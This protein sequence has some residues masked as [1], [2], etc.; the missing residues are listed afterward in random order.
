MTRIDKWM[1]KWGRASSSVLETVLE[2]ARNEPQAR[3]SLLGYFV[4]LGMPCLLGYSVAVW[5][6]PDAKWVN[7][8]QYSLESDLN[9]ATISIVPIPHDCDFFTA[10]IGAKH[11]RYYKHV[12][13]VRIR[14]FLSGRFVSTDEGNTW[15]K[16]KPSDHSAV[17]ISWEKV[18]D[19]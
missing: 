10:P 15:A 6:W 4:M 12:L 9:D 16:A 11:C 2:I 19:W 17:F 8:L 5:L 7:Q 18:Q 13:T 3:S 14:T 1:D